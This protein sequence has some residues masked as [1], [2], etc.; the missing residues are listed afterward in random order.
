MYKYSYL[1]KQNKDHV[2]DYWRRK[3]ITPVLY[4]KLHI[5]EYSNK[6]FSYCT[7]LSNMLLQDNIQFWLHTE[8]TQ[9]LSVQCP[10]F[11]LFK[12]SFEGLFQEST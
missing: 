5:N 12:F 6:A 10:T 3:L 8:L 7:K 2:E 4:N 1:N 11:I 9:N